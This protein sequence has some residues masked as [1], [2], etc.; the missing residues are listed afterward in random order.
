MRV[1]PKSLIRRLT[2]TATRALEAAVGRAAGSG[3]YEI[4]VEHLLAQILEPDEGDVARILHEAGADRQKLHARV[5]RELQRMKTGNPGRP[6][7]SENVF[8]WLEDAWLVASVELG[9]TSLRTGH[10]LLQIVARPDRYTG[11]S[12]AELEGLKI[13]DL[14]RDLDTVLAPSP[15]S[16]EA[17]PIAAPGAPGRPAAAGGE[18]LARF[19]Q[20][21]TQKARDGQIDPIFGRHREIRQV[22]DILARRRKNNPIIVGEP[23]VGAPAGCPAGPWPEGA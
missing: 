11:E 12:Y 16:L 18:A 1:E 21:F 15:E 17:A 8:N 23:G 6:V 10:L 7:I 14:R 3:F 9:A 19:C 2:P 22:I 5:E 20:N 13:D 4:T